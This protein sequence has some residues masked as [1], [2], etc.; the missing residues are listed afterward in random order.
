MP[1]AAWMRCTACHSS[2]LAEWIVDSVSQSSSR[3]GG[4]ARSL[5]SA[6]RVE[7]ELDEEPAAARVAGGGGGQLLDVG[8]AGCGVVVVGREHQLAEGLQPLDLVGGGVAVMLETVG[9]GGAQL[10][11]RADGRGGESTPAVDEPAHGVDFGVADAQLVV[12]P[13]HRGGTH[14]LEGG[15]HSVPRQLVVGI[16]EDAQ[17]G[18]EVLDVGGFE[19]REAAVLHVGDVAP[20]ELELEGVGVVAGPEQHRLGPQ[21]EAP[22]APVEHRVG[23]RAGLGALVVGV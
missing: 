3:W 18:E 7:G 23:H 2:P 17:Q 19:V 22:L 21:V 13:A 10:V 12:E 20:G 6:W 4:P 5:G 8:E 14:S 1:S 16:V 15:Q 9:E 11:A